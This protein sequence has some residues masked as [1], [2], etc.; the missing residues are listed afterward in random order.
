MTTFD[1][2]GMPIRVEDHA[3]DAVTDDTE[4]TLTDYVRNTSAWL[5]RNR[6]QDPRSS[7]SPVR[8]LRAAG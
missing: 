3:D 4:C 2:Y 5:H 8:P 6:R 7:P 1:S